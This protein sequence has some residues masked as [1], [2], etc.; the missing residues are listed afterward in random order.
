MEFDNSLAF[1]VFGFPSISCLLH[2]LI[3]IAS[4]SLKHVRFIAMLLPAVFIASQ[5]LTRRGLRNGGVW[6]NLSA[7]VI[8]FMGWCGEYFHTS[9]SQVTWTQEITGHCPVSVTYCILWDESKITTRLCIFCM[10]RY[11]GVLRNRVC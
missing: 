11:G 4:S 5:Q 7:G 3:S 8:Q 1:F 10:F 2:H 9:L 6:R